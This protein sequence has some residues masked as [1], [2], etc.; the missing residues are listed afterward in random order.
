[1][2]W[3]VSNIQFFQAID[4][5]LIIPKL[6]DS[7]KVLTDKNDLEYEWAVDAALKK[8]KVLIYEALKIKQGIWDI[9]FQ[10][11]GDVFELIKKCILL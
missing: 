11:K 5:D 7:V 10:E 1:M 4:N 6:M 3:M 9:I 8:R 2:R